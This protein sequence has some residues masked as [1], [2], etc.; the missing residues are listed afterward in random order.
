MDRAGKI[1]AV[2]Y[3]STALLL[4]QPRAIWAVPA[5]GRQE[6]SAASEADNTGN[7]EKNQ[8]AVQNTTSAKDQTL[9]EKE[10]GTEKNPEIGKAAGTKKI[11]ETGKTAETEK[12]A[13]TG[14][15]VETGKNVETEKPPEEGKTAETEKT[16]ETGNSSETG[17]LTATDQTTES[18]SPPAPE[19]DKGPSG[20]KNEESGS[21]SAES[22]DLYAS[23]SGKDSISTMRKGKQGRIVVYV[24]SDSLKTEEVGKNGITLSKL[25]DSFRLSGSPKVKVT[26]GKGELL[27]FT[28]TF[29]NVTY[30]GRGNE[31]RFRANY[32]KAGIP[33]ESLSV[34]I[35]ET[36]E[37][38]SSGDDDGEITGQPVVTVRR[39]SPQTPVGAG[40]T[41]TLTL[42]VE[43]TSKDADIEDLMVSLNPSDGLFVID[44]TN[45]R[46]VS[47]LDTKRSSEITWQMKAG[48]DIADPSKS[49]DVELKYNY[50]AGGRITAATASQK[51]VLPLKGGGS[52]GQPQLRIGRSGLAQPVTA[53]EK[54][55]LML[56]LENTSK[57][58]EIRNLS[59]V[60]ETNEQLALMEETDTKLIGDLKPGQTI[61]IPIRLQAASELSSSA[62]SM[63][64]VN[65]KF[66][67]DSD[68]GISQ[69]TY[70]E[71][72]VVPTKGGGKVGVSTPNLIIG[73]YT[74]GDKVS[75][76][77]V[78]D[79][80]LE[81]LNTSSS[82]SVENVIMS[83]DTG[84]GISINS[85]SNTIY[86][87]RMEP[88]ER[89]KETVRVQAL[90]QSK[91]QSPKI[92]IAFRY[93]F[94]DKTERKQNTSNETIAIPV[95][96]PDRFELKHPILAEQYRS[97]EEAT[98]SLPYVNKGRGQIFNVEAKLEGDI[99]TLER[100]LSLGN[101]EAGK[102]GTID[103]VVTP[104][105]AGT[106]EGKV[107]VSYED[108]AMQIKQLEVPV[109]FTVGEAQEQQSSEFD[110]P[111][112]EAGSPWKRRV[113]FAAIAA[114]AVLAGGVWRARRRKRRHAEEEDST[115]DGY[116]DDEYREVHEYS[117]DDEYRVAHEYSENDEYSE[118]HEK[119]ASSSAQGKMDSSIDSSDEHPV[120]RGERS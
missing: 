112:P 40:E 89:R 93:E 4:S 28:A 24:K 16:P 110:E 65:L 101:F 96:Q 27:E 32:K 80:Q 59:A 76:G 12:T 53:G 6:I 57:E 44:D 99:Q 14:K 31:L 17:Q 106:F 9:A 34:E 119:G 120:G 87:P 7:Q 92:T 35:A 36:E 107:L 47:R 72:V 11:P 102:S 13:E 2:L 84:E 45:S 98:I 50:Y 81:L 78:F 67:Y 66:D 38:G 30:T 37:S 82:S 85:S 62:A 61:T 95:Y 1:K 75:A 103:F 18:Q 79:L 42:K 26:S 25:K 46:L 116:E 19:P 90:F 64:G 91:L 63:L 74:Y 33:S 48:Q 70:A 43:N 56:Y 58:K 104:Q 83:L 22:Y 73:T 8:N 86:I 54:F 113:L 114:G 52:F 60:F 71:K 115:S 105:N 15:I 49:V 29:P 88:G 41:F 55:D 94:M 108:E 97:Q 118:A 3:L 5:A 39:I 68:K 77:E 100:E 23:G 117:E 69:G 20:E 51:V 109:T 10:A 21:L 111:Y